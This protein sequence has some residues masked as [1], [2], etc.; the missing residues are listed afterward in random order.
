MKKKHKNTSKFTFFLDVI[1]HKASEGEDKVI[2]SCET[3][4]RVLC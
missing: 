4:T 1:Y 3:K 2:R